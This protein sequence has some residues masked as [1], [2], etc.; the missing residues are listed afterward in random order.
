MV[1][2]IGLF[3]ISMFLFVMSGL[4]LFYSLNTRRDTKQALSQVKEERGKLIR[5]E[6]AKRRLAAKYRRNL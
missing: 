3:I 2:V 1:A 6:D 4:Y 5:L